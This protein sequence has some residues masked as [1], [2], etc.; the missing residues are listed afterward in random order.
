MSIL[1]NDPWKF[2]C[3]AHRGLRK[4][5]P[6]NTLLAFKKAIE[7]K[8]TMLELDVQMTKDQ[9][10]VVLHDATLQRLANVRQYVS[11]MSWKELNQISLYDKQA[12]HVR[13][14][15]V[16]TLKKL[17]QKIGKQTNY[18]VEIKAFK[19]HSS[20]YRRLLCD[21][22]VDLIYRYDLL[23][24]VMIVSFDFEILSYLYNHYKP[25][26]LG[27]N[28]E[29]HWPTHN[30]MSTLRRMH[31]VL[32][33]QECLLD[34]H[35]LRLSQEKGFRIIPWVVNKTKNMQRFI[36]NQVDG[37]ITDYPDRLYEAKK[38]GP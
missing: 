33:P 23:K 5:Y 4:L 8:A 25:L 7:A 35:H 21:S 9:V 6:E 37:I 26:H 38:L 14:G 15:K 11:E 28:F 34:D 29:K 16:L 24:H 32:C 2:Q 36:E 13:Q 22:V 3:I 10:V 19:K 18:Y 27:F 12:Q 30:R 31:A 1:I 20:Q 17:F